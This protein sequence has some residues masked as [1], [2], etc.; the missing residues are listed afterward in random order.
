MTYLANTTG[1]TT[2]VVM[3]TAGSANP[4]RLA[5]VSVAAAGPDMTP[6]KAQITPATTVAGV[7]HNPNV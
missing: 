1:G 2:S 4:S 5:I 7:M 3:N 6:R